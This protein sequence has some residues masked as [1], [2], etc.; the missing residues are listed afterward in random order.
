LGNEDDTF[1]AVRRGLVDGGL[2]RRAVV[3][4]ARG[5]SSRVVKAELPGWAEAAMVPARNNVTER[6]SFFIAKA[7]AGTANFLSRSGT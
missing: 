1:L 6:S 5:S 2:D 7:P 3:T 4:A